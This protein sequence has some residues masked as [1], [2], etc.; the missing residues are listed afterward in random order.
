MKKIFILLISS[1]LFGWTLLTGS[2]KGWN[3][4][5]L[6]IGV[7]T[8]DCTLSDGEIHSIVDDAIHAWNGIPMADLILSRREST[9]A[10]SEVLNGTAID[11][12]VIVCDPSF[13]SNIGSSSVV[14]GVTLGVQLGSDYHIVQGGM[15]LNAQAGAGAEISNFTHDEMVIV[16]AHELGHAL[17]LG[18]SGD[19]Q[20]LMYFSI[21]GKTKA[22]ITED[23]M[24]GMAF[25]YPRNEFSGKPLGCAAVHERGPVSMKRVMASAFL[26][27][28]ISLGSIFLGRKF[29][30]DPQ[31]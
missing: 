6:A 27:I 24:D 5:T 28:F 4:K 1:P 18:H 16:V 13:E 15:V 21:S 31:T 8:Q 17:G 10:V 11:A 20:S 14:P 2:L 25:L 30:K 12:P 29:L 26:T 9:T 3:T 7:N 19:P 22:Q 23:D